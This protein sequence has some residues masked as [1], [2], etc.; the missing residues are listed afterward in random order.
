MILYEAIFQICPQN[1]AE[2]IFQVD[3]PRIKRF[4]AR[5]IVHDS[6]SRSNNGRRGVVHSRVDQG[7]KTENR[8]EQCPAESSVSSP[9]KMIVLVPAR[10]MVVGLWFNHS[11]VDPGGK[12]ENRFEP[13]QACRRRK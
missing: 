2:K 13:N 5:K 3:R 11:R 1:H 4:G 6:S 12:T 7:G 10:T 9:E 8:F